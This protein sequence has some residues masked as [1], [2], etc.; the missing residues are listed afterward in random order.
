MTDKEPQPNPGPKRRGELDAMGMF[1]VVG[2]VFFHSAMFFYHG[3]FY[4]KAGVS[5][6]AADLLTGFGGMWGMPLMFII[7]GMAIWYSLRKRS[8]EEFVRERIRRL[9]VPFVVG[10]LLLVPPIVY[11]SLKTDPSYQENYAQFLGRFFEI[12]LAFEFPLFIDG[13]LFT[14]GHLW[15]V[16]LLFAYTILLLPVW[17]YLRRPEGGRLIER[18]AVFCDRWGAI[19][20]LGIPIGLIEAALGTEMSGNWNRFSYFPILIYGFLFA[21]TPRISRTL[22]KYWKLSLILGIMGQIAWLAGYMYLAEVVGVS[23]VSGR[24]L[25]EIGLRF[26]KGMTCWFWI[27]TIMGLAIGV[28]QKGRRSERVKS[29]DVSNDSEPYEESLMD[30]IGQYAREAQLPFYVLHYTPL[31]IIGFFVL[32]WQVGATIQYFVIVISTLVV[33]LLLYDL[34][35]RRTKLTRFLFGMRPSK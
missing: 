31:I 13:D 24:G 25:G 12:K 6:S 20:L 19:F 9:F 2:L 21:A 17:S 34:G 32:Q 22:R 23:P 29:G 35:V 18:I 11:F 33:T 15:F 30:R 28:G 8:L 14:D 4:F 5:T 7:A 16:I 10:M 26:L 3:E 1:V 27:V